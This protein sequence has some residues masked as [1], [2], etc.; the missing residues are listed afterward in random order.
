MNASTRT[1]FNES[2]K[3]AEAAYQ[4]FGENSPEYRQAARRYAVAGEK[5]WGENEADVQAS[6]RKTLSQE[7]IDKVNAVHEKHNR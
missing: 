7:S 3:A 4:K 2:R 5:Y 1:E 6:L